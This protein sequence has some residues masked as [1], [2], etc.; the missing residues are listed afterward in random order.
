MLQKTMARFPIAFTT[1]AFL[2]SACSGGG[3]G[4]LPSQP[5]STGASPQAVQFVTQ[6]TT[7]ALPE[8]LTNY[9]YTYGTDDKFTPNDGDS[10]SGGQGL[11]INTISG[12][13]TLTCG[14]MSSDIKYYHI[15]T[16]V[17]VLVNGAPYSTPDAI[18]IDV[19]GPEDSHNGTN[20]GKCFYAIH[21]HDASGLVHIET[22]LTN[23][24]YNTVVYYLGDL[25]HVWGQTITSTSF[26]NFAGPV[27]IFIAPPRG[28]YGTSNFQYSGTYAKYTGD[29]TLIPLKTHESIWIEVG[30]TVTP[31][32]VHFYTAH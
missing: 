30:S 15:H 31:P 13:N 20:S 8:V 2:L 3:G 26:A 5:A 23:T 9:G 10:Q 18:G 12:K 25:L 27:T 21:S 7:A 17:G 32:V 24:S 1:L 4:V 19:P 11:P 16:Y 6:A 28:A 29:P 22:Y 14:V